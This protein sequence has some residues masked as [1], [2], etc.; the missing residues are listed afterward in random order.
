VLCFALKMLSVKNAIYSKVSEEGDD[1]R[2]LRYFGQT[3]PLVTTEYCA[4]NGEGIGKVTTPLDACI[5]NT[6]TI[7]CRGTRKHSS[8]FASSS[9]NNYCITR[10]AA[11]KISF[12]NGI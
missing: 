1:A 9:S 11:D 3:T 5:R 7:T 4:E 10:S 6:E 8:Q 12:Q 2:A